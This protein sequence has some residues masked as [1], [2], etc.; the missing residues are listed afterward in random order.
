MS[1]PKKEIDVKQIIRE[2]AFKPSKAHKA[3]KFREQIKLLNEIVKIK[4]APSSIHGVGVFAMRD[5][6]KGEKLYADTVTHQFDLPY[7]L[8]SKLDKDIQDTILGF[9]PLVVNGSHFLYPVTRMA[10]FLNHSDTP[11]YD[12]KEDKAL[13]AIKAGEEVTEDYRTIIGW[14]IVHP[15]LNK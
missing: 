7:N 13:R 9:F 15:W 6:K 14:D 12:A 8:F 1:K 11:N 10:A 5:I 3:K 2:V 4:I